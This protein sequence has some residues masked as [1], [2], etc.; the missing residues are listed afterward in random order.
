M[1][2]LQTL[3]IFSAVRKY[4]YKKAGKKDVRILP[5]DSKSDEK[6]FVDR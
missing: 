1:K 2:S 4:G 3:S 5:Q 6:Y